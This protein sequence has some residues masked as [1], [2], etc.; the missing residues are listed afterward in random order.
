MF[1][2]NFQD[3]KYQR[4]AISYYLNNWNA[5]FFHATLQILLNTFYQK[6]SLNSLP[7]GNFHS[8]ITLTKTLW[9]QPRFAFCEST[10]IM[11]VHI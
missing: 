5:I 4:R 7:K 9:G 3:E 10:A 2:K 8:F 1:A 11:K 6:K